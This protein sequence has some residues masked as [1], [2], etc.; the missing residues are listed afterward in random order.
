MKEKYLLARSLQITLIVIYFS[1]QLID[2]RHITTTQ[3]M[4][5]CLKRHLEYSTNGGNI[6]PL[7]TILPQRKEP[8]KDFQI[9]NTLMLSWAGYRQ[10]DGTVIGD[11]ASVEFTEVNHMPYTQS[12]RELVVKMRSNFR[13]I[14]PAT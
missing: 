9:W 7:I 12:M 6:R 11:P 5:E 3:E 4:F 2:A 13:V 8:N 1:Y 14:N 10:P